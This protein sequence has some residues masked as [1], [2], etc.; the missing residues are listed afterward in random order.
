MHSAIGI[1]PTSVGVTF[2]Q[3]FSRVFL[4]WPIL[5]CVSESR[6][7]IGFPLLLTA[8]TVTEVMRYL[9]YALS[10]ISAVPYALQW[11]R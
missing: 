3:V 6:D 1:V 7:Q 10:L 2:P 9:F 11:C 8:W 5:Y 4:I